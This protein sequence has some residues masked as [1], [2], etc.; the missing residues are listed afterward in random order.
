MEPSLSSSDAQSQLHLPDRMIAWLCGIERPATSQGPMLP[1]NTEAGDLLERLG[2]ES[3]DRATALAARPDPIAH[4]ALWWVLDRMYHEMLANMGTPPPASYGGWP[5]LPVETGP[6]GRHLYVWLCLAILPHVR[7]YHSAVGVPDEISWDSLAALGD[8]MTSSRLISGISGMDATW[9]M[10]RVFRGASYRLGRLAFDRQQPQP[11][12][13]DHPLLHPGQS[14]LNTH[15]RAG[16]GRL[17]PAACDDSFAQAREFFPRR[18]PEQ[19]AGFGCHSW[20]MDDQLAAYLPETSNIIRFQRRFKIFTDCELADW[21]PLEHLFHRR[22][23]GPRVPDVLLNE[24]PQETMLQ[25][26]VVTHL[27]NGGHWYNRTGW[28]PFKA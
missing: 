21:A 8:E 5:A 2:V 12:L 7:R 22:Y 28:F 14:G 19:V 18:F 3:T 10:P 20:L 4:P 26:A 25:R 9:G 23:N 1:S 15:V 27:R 11:D 6:V 24:L 17:H 16:G 13:S